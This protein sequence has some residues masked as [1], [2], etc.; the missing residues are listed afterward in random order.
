[1]KSIETNIAKTY[2]E[3]KLYLLVLAGVVSYDVDDS[4][5]WIERMV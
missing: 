2:R 4:S 3:E 5:G 1:M